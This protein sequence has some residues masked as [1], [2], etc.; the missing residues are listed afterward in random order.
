ML[1]DLAQNDDCNW[2]IIRNGM[3]ADPR[4]GSSHLMPVHASGTLGSDNYRLLPKKNKKTKGGRGAGGHCFI[5]DFAAFRQLY[6]ESFPKDREGVAV[7]E[8]LERK[9][10]K[11]LKSSQKDLDLLRGVYGKTI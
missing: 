7:L 10:I 6:K 3:S 11:L 4:V 1:Y 9:N 5:K 2:E 8:A